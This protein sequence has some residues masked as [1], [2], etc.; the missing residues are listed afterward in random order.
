[1]ASRSKANLLK[2]VAFLLLVAA[3]V[4]TLIGLSFEVE[5][6]SGTLSKVQLAGE[7]L[8]IFTPD[9]IR[10]GDEYYLAMAPGR[11]P[12]AAADDSTWSIDF[13]GDKLRVITEILLLTAIASFISDIFVS[14]FVCKSSPV[15]CAGTISRVST[16]L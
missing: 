5:T 14:V 1:M 10:E 6:A 15:I 2:P 7:T 16:S 8:R 3:C 12:P 9:S 4:W 11:S 13:N